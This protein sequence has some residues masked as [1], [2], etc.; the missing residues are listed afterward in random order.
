MYSEMTLRSAIFVRPFTWTYLTS[1]SYSF[2]KNLVNASVVSYMWLSA[3]KTGKSTTPFDMATSVAAITAGPG[4]ALG[5]FSTSTSILYPGP[6]RATTRWPGVQARTSGRRNRREGGGINGD[7]CAGPR[8]WARWLVLPA[9]GPPPPRRGARG[10][11]PDP[12]RARG[13]GAPVGRR[14]RPGAAR[15]RRGRRAALR[16]SARRDP[17]RTQL[18]GHGD[19]RRGRPGGGPGGPSRLPGCSDAKQRSVAGR[20]GRTGH[21]RGAADG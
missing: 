1:P 18:R 4:D 17:G 20:R 21:Q 3:S 15:H 12:H 16:G 2:G 13:P 7:L 14:G 10:A 8:W 5:R 19:H 9:G 6:S 11:H